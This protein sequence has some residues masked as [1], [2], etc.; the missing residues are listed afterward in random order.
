MVAENTTRRVDIILSAK[1]NASVTLDRASM[2]VRRLKAEASESLVYGPAVKPRFG[3]FEQEARDIAAGKLRAL[4]DAA[5]RANV[6]ERADEILFGGSQAEKANQVAGAETAESF[7][8]GFI[9]RLKEK[10]GRGS[11]FQGSL[12]L[13][14]GGGALIG[15]SLLGNIL[16][17]STEKAKEFAA[18][19]RE[20]KLSAAELVV[21][22]GEA[23]PL[24]SSFVTAG[25]NI[26]ELITGE[27]A[28]IDRTLEFAKAIDAA[29]DANRRAGEA[30]AKAYEDMASNAERMERAARLAALVGSESVRAM[31]M[32]AEQDREGQITSQRDA[33]IES[34]RKAAEDAA[35]G[36][37]AERS[38]IVNSG[39]LEK[40][41]IGPGADADTIDLNSSFVGTQ[42]KE[43]VK[44]YREAH[45][46]LGTLN[47]QIDAITRSS[48][49]DI[50]A[51]Q[52]EGQQQLEASR[53]QFRA[54]REQSEYQR[55]LDQDEKSRQ[56]ESGLSGIGTAAD[57]RVAEINRATQ[58]EYLISQGRLAEAEILG[59]R[60]DFDR[61]RKALDEEVAA[62]REAEAEA[63]RRKTAEYNRPGRTVE[64]FQVQLDAYAEAQERTRTVI[65][66]TNRVK[67]A[68]NEQQR[69]SELAAM[70]KAAQEKENM[71]RTHQQAI[72]D[73][74]TKNAADNL[75]AMGL[76]A[77]AEELELRES[78]E[79]KLAEIQAN[80]DRETQL[81]A[82]QREVLKQQAA[83]SVA[84][85]NDNYRAKLVDI[86]RQQNKFAPDRPSALGESRMLTGGLG[87]G[88][89]NALMQPTERVAKASEATAYTNKQIVDAV[90]AVVRI[91]TAIPTQLPQVLSAN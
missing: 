71:E 28:E 32:G 78:H 30:A 2:N 72:T 74:R 44:A 89:T 51:I 11:T 18:A 75:R 80:L 61:Q 81:H 31:A 5:R 58:R 52:R 21:K 19:L 29:I 69:V 53:K 42:I 67:S 49:Q 17:S 62:A 15:F 56:R 22:F 20:G 77:E 84:A 55:K 68:L 64:S 86:D 91:L 12:E 37:R 70:A 4:R 8:G 83:E 85:E 27:Q 43:K 23:V 59:I 3:D 34:R 79:R 24:V 36:L 7:H 1:D 13:L 40:P 65:A 50:A 57:E 16:E 82:D 35:K 48:D 39:L 38:Q 33:A 66:N 73:I 9:E 26:R 46:R 54:E 47:K 41:N 63:E 90:Q 6:R 60:A 25:Q 87:E 45:N 88:M 14:K 76:D 10:F